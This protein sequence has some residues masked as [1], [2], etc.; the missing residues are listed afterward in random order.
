MQQMQEV[1]MAG[2]AKSTGNYL[3]RE[4]FI[5]YVNKSRTGDRFQGQRRKY[6][7]ATNFFK[8]S[9]RLSGCGFA[10]I[11]RWLQNTINLKLFQKPILHN[12]T[13]SRCHN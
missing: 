3:K 4:R 2:V 13:V 7:K 1:Q 12:A 6:K 5:A 9:C 10:F 8:T 11:K